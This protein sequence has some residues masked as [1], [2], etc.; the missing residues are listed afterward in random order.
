MAKRKEIDD[1]IEGFSYPE[2]KIRRL[3][4]HP[5]PIALSFVL[6]RFSLLVFVLTVAN[7]I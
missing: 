2:F 3:V 6:L 1:A 5:L 7:S 4:R